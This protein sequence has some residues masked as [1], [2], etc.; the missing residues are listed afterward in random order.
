VVHPWCTLE[1]TAG[2]PLLVMADARYEC[3]QTEGCQHKAELN[4]AEGTHEV[5]R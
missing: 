5:M 2:R 1:Q 3:R 4:R